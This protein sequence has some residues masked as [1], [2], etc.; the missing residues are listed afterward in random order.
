MEM[1]R[2]ID[3]H[4]YKEFGS[5]YERQLV[6]LPIG[7]LPM[8]KIE[9]DIMYIDLP[10]GLTQGELIAQCRDELKGL[11]SQCYGKDIKINGRI[12]TGMALFLGHALAHI[13]KSVSIFDPKENTYFVAVTH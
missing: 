3:S 13:T 11:E 12:T 7:A 2:T 4:I 9:G 1:N 5:A 6:K 10:Q 8:L